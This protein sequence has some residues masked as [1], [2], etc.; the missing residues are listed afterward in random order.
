MTATPSIT[1][2]RAAAAPGANWAGW[3]GYTPTA[4]GPAERLA[5]A[6]AAGL[7]DDGR[8]AER[9]AASAVRLS[10]GT[11]NLGVLEDAVRPRREPS[12]SF[13]G[14]M[15]GRTSPMTRRREAARSCRG[16]AAGRGSSISKA[17]RAEAPVSGV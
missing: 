6:R 3:A 9:D 12:R 2:A 17:R 10:E 5:R 14:S 8:G 16:S 1:G 11:L 15:A 7:V 13:R 4:R